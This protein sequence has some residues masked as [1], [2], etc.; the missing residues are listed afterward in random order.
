[1]FFVKFTSQIEILSAFVLTRVL[2]ICIL[3]YRA[4]GN[5]SNI[6]G[7]S[8][9]GHCKI[10]AFLSVIQV[11]FLI[12]KEFIKMITLDWSIFG[13]TKFPVSLISHFKNTYSHW[14]M[15]W[16]KYLR[17]LKGKIYT[18]N[19]FIHKLKKMN[20]SNKF[21]VPK[22]FVIS[23]VYIISLMTTYTCNPQLK[24]TR[25]AFMQNLSNFWLRLMISRCR[26]IVLTRC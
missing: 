7:L 2:N 11:Y 12:S 13:D 24:M 22:S 16:N 14:Q 20:W 17:F 18:F 8:R 23:L 4:D 3:F 9:Y 19:S 15:S 21:D 26:L 5:Q 25:D 1:M 10:S 6:Y